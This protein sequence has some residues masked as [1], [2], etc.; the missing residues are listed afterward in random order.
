MYPIA[1]Q[2]MFEASNSRYCAKLSDNEANKSSKRTQFEIENILKNNFCDTSVTAESEIDKNSRSHQYSFD[3]V[4]IDD[5]LPKKFSVK[6]QSDGLIAPDSSQTHKFWIKNI[7]V[8]DDIPG[9]NVLLDLVDEKIE[10]KSLKSINSN[11]ELLLWFSEEILS[12]MGIPFLTPA[13]IQG[14]TTTRSRV[15]KITRKL[16]G[17][18]FIATETACLANI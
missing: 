17:S 8:A 14:E 6:M 10:L 2:F 13:N 12:F 9:A 4:L 18:L 7:R 3:K 5:N 11:D 16:D 15:S 1:S